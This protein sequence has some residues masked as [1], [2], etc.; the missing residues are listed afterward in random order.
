MSINYAK[1][2]DENGD[3][4]EEVLEKNRWLKFLTETIHRR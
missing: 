2:F 1:F 4:R 3:V